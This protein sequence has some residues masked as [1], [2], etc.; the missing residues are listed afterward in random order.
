MRNLDEF[1]SFISVSR[2]RLLQNDT[3]LKY[4]RTKTLTS[5]HWDSS[6]RGKPSVEIPDEL[7]GTWDVHEESHWT[8][9]TL[10]LSAWINNCNADRIKLSPTADKKPDFRITTTIKTAAVSSRQLLSALKTDQRASQSINIFET[11]QIT[12]KTVLLK[13]KNQLW[14]EECVSA[15]VS[16]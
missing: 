11:N 6:M 9:K 10:F 12:T 4:W 15:S 13:V 14:L 2:S 3:L 16:Q 8:V 7:R 1:L 5:W